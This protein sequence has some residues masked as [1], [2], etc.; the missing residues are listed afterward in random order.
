MNR[1]DQSVM[2]IEPDPTPPGPSAGWLRFRSRDLEDRY[3]Q[4]EYTRNRPWIVGSVTL[5]LLA[6]L[7]FYPLDGLF[8]PPDALADAHVIRTAAIVI[9]TLIGLVGM[10]VIRRASLAIPFAFG[11]LFVVN[12]AWAAMLWVSGPNAEAY[13]AFGIAQTC[14]FTYSCIALPFRWSIVAVA[15]ALT[16]FLVLASGNDFA[17][18]DFWFT[19]ASLVTLF[20]IATYGTIRYERTSRERFL[21]QHRLQEEYALRLAVEHDR[22]QWLG[23]VAGFVRHEIKNAMAGVGSSLELLERSGLDAER[24]QYTDRAQRSLRFMRNVLDRVANATNLERALDVQETE[25]LNLSQ[26]VRERLEDFR[27]DRSLLC[28]AR[29]EP[30][31]RVRGNTDSLAQ[32][33]DKLLDNAID[34]SAPNEPIVVTLE[35]S[36]GRVRLSIEDHG[37]PLPDAVE[38]LFHPFATDGGS[39]DAHLGLGLY[40]AQVIARH[41]RGTIRATPTADRPGAAFVVD[42]PALR[43]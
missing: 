36:D 31:V 1:E 29:I 38:E 34:H 9:P 24:K 28:D 26:L 4:D 23:V 40:V 35:K 20:V 10:A 33:L 5:G 13:L 12:L 21:A 22:S 39:G 7:A 8:V 3:L 19:T 6:A 25:D 17:P 32:M 15:M 37:D 2:P 14:L 43:S 27:R 11:C 42:L 30:D 18:R 41:H 16:V